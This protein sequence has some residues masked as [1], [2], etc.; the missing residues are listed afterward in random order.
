MAPWAP[1]Y[2]KARFSVLKKLAVSG[3]GM[4]RWRAGG[5]VQGPSGDLTITGSL[6]KPDADTTDWSLNPDLWIRILR[7]MQPVEEGLLMLRK[8]AM[9]NSSWKG[10]AGALLDPTSEWQA[11]RLAAMKAGK[12][13]LETLL[14]DLKPTGGAYTA[15]MKDVHSTWDIMRASYMTFSLHNTAARLLIVISD[16]RTLTLTDVEVVT[17]GHALTFVECRFMLYNSL[18]TAL[19]R[20]GFLQTP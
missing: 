15:C 5:I 16:T 6:R 18:V 19:V 12:A 2:S 10:Y 3:S 8:S 9:V 4:I 11:R 7:R 14:N 13:Q 20:H 17:R 1:F